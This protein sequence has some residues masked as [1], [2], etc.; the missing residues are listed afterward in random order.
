MTDSE[1]PYIL[2]L[3]Y[4]RSGGTAN[5]ARHITE[6]GHRHG[7]EVLKY[8]G[9]MNHMKAM[10]IDGGVANYPIEQCWTDYRINA[11]VLLPYA[12]IAAGSIDLDTVNDRGRELFEA[13]FER[14]MTAI[15][16]LE[17]FSLV[18]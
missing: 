1:A 6:R 4:S 12:V 8:A 9:G 5:L 17:S 16:D 14:Y 7:F 11:M 10:L 18:T 2:V 3:Y 13:M 15:V